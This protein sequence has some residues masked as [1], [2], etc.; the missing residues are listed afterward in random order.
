MTILNRKLD[1]DILDSLE[2]EDDIRNEIEQTDLFNDEIELTILLLDEAFS[3]EPDEQPRLTE[4]PREEGNDLATING[5]TSAESTSTTGNNTAPPRTRESESPVSSVSS[6][7]H[8]PA[9]EVLSCAVKL[10]N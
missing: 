8:S 2:S 5:H 1:S 6:R 9:E 4:T 10:P 3:K 7:H